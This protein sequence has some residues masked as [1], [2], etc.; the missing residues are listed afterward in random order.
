VGATLRLIFGERLG[1]AR[2]I[3]GGSG[4]WSQDSAIQI[5]S[6]PEPPTGIWVRWPGGKTTTSA[7]PKDA[8]EIAVELDG[9]VTSLR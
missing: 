5:L 2:E 9:K 8:T 6:G 3:H 7:V 1:P 4:Y